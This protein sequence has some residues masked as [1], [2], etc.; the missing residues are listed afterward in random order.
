GKQLV[1]NYKAA[2]TRRRT[3]VMHFGL[4]AY[5]DSWGFKTFMTMQWYD[6]LTCQS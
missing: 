5:R 4:V 1:V 3:R 6:M 2:Q